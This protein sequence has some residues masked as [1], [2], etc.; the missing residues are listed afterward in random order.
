MK[1][2]FPLSLALA[3]TLFL[4]G[5]GSDDDTPTEPTQTKIDM[6][7]LQGDYNVQYKVVS[8]STTYSIKY[9]RRNHIAVKNDENGTWNTANGHTLVTLSAN[10]DYNTTVFEVNHRYLDNGTEVEVT[11]INDAPCI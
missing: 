11:K 4:A 6:Q 1:Y 5:C 8:G 7:N 10:Y 2:V 3:S 9:C